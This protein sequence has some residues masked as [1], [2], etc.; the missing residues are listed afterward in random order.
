M[1]ALGACSTPPS[2]IA[3]GDGPDDSSTTDEATTTPGMTTPG[4]DTTN[5]SHSG[6]GTNGT[7]TVDPPVSTGDTTMD[8]PSTSG[9]TTVGVDPTTSGSS[10]PMPECTDPEDCGSNQTCIAGMCVAACN[11]WGDGHYGYCLTPLGTFDSTVLCG[12]ALSCINS[13][14]PIEVVVC[15][16]TCATQCDCPEPP[17]TGTATVTC[18]DLAGTDRCYLSC[19]NGEACP[20]DMVCRFGMYCAHPVQDLDMYGNCGAVASGCANGGV[21][22]T[23]SGMNDWAVCVSSCGAV[24][25]CD[26]APAGAS[27]GQ[28]CGQVYTS[29]GDECHLDCNNNGDC[30]AG[31]GCV[32]IGVGY[33]N[34]CMWQQ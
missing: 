33:G 11:P 2:T 14:D 9:D 15:G 31:M 18:G 6:S 24:G 30:P 27:Q 8:D 28:G 34:F 20:D 16:R 32:D 29:A 21:C 7:T 25:D 22:A 13:G 4:Q 17:P 3:S 1:L 12:E 26:P 23:A 5:G 19:E 10:G